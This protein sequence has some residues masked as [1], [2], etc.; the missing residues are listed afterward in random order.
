MK[1]VRW[2]RPDPLAQTWI[3]QLSGWSVFLILLMLQLLPSAEFSL[4]CGW[5]SETSVP[6]H[7]HI[8]SPIRSFQMSIECRFFG[9]PYSVLWHLVPVLTSDAS[10]VVHVHVLSPPWIMDHSASWALILINF[11]GMPWC[12]R[13]FHK[14]SLSILSNAFSES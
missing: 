9:Y 6:D 5:R 10:V 12:L 13:I 4:A 2:V 11:F 8:P 3:S 1:F 14:V 7:L